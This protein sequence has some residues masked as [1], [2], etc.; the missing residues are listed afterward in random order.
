MNGVEIK[1]PADWTDPKNTALRELYTVFPKE[2]EKYKPWRHLV[3][4]EDELVYNIED[5]TSDLEEW[6]KDKMNDWSP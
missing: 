5:I 6:D 4:K 1:I 3:G 2:Q